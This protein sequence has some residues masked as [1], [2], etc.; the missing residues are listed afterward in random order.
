MVHNIPDCYLSNQLGSAAP[1]T[2]GSSLSGTVP[3]SLP[4]SGEG[5]WG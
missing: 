3:G 1:I 5:G 4:F 2:M